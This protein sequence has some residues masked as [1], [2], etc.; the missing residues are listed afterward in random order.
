MNDHERVFQHL[1]QVLAETDPRRLTLPFQVAEL[2]E[3]IIPYRRH[4]TALGFDA[5]EDYEMALL[6]LLAGEGDLAEVEPAE[7]LEALVQEVEA[8]NPEPGAFRYFAA[9][10]VRLQSAA[11]RRVLD[12]PQAYAPPG[13]AR[14]H[15][16]NEVDEMMRPPSDDTDAQPA[17]PSSLPDREADRTSPKTRD[18]STPDATC[19]RC[20]ASLPAGRH[21]VFCPFCGESVSSFSCVNCGEPLERGWRHCITC[22]TPV[23]A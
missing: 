2:Y 13:A 22:G 7:A 23:V 14:D 18:P 21:V 19:P 12:A 16:V 1:V 4:R 20:D 15:T 3:E 11:V 17:E 5:V 8:V 6:R 10:T 9:A